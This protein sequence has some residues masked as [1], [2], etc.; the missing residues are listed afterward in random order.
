MTADSL[1]LLTATPRFKCSG[2]TA[3]RAGAV[4]T[5]PARPALRHGTSPSI[6]SEWMHFAGRAPA[7]FGPRVKHACIDKIARPGVKTFVCRLSLSRR[8]PGPG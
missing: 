1:K 3:P 7:R 2:A 4:Q 6:C 8:N 5:S